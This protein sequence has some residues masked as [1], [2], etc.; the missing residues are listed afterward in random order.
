MFVP[1]HENRIV[2]FIYASQVL[3]GVTSRK[4][5]GRSARMCDATIACVLDLMIKTQQKA[6]TFLKQNNRSVQLEFIIAK[7][8]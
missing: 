2:G 7:P 3:V 5:R 4:S 1:I 8:F 6:F